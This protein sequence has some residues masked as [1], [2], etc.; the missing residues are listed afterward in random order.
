LFFFNGCATKDAIKSV[1]AEEVLKQRVHE[2][3]GHKINR[4]FGEAYQYEYAY[5]M[6]VMPLT[7]YI[8]LNSNPM[9]TYKSFELKSIGWK[10]EDVADVEL[11]VVPVAK[12]PGAKPFEYP[13]IVTE[14]W[15]RVNESWYRVGKGMMHNLTQEKE[16]GGDVKN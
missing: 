2:Y 4:E 13:V 11:S 14:R 8:E 15:V 12:A 1:S 16:K 5:I 10:R 3:W 9:I 6:K 7:K